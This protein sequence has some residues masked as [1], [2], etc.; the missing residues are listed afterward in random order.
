MTIPRMQKSS[1]LNQDIILVL[2]MM[3]ALQSQADGGGGSGHM[4]YIP[5][6]T[7][8]WDLDASPKLHVS[9]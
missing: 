1:R 9:N 2:V 4:R 7:Q 3:E 8:T 6:P 5:R